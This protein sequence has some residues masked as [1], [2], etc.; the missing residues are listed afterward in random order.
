MTQQSR[1]V[2]GLRGALVKVAGRLFVS[3]NLL[4]FQVLLVWQQ[5]HVNTTQGDL[6]VKRVLEIL[7]HTQKPSKCPSPKNDSC[8]PPKK[9][10]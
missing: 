2:P 7:I 9:G 6:E 1:E 5:P 4:V 3:R 10:R 8:L